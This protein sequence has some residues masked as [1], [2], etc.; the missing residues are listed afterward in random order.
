MTD[1][2]KTKINDRYLIGQKF[3][4]GSFGDVFVGTSCNYVKNL[5]SSN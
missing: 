4:S 5:F 3:G 1:F 2:E